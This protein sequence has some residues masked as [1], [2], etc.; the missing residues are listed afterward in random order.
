MSLEE[1]YAKHHVLTDGLQR[2][3]VINTHER[4]YDLDFVTPIELVVLVPRE[5]EEG[6]SSFI[7]SPAVVN[8]KF[9]NRAWVQILKE[10]VI[11]LQSK[12]PKTKEELLAFR[13]DWS[14]API[15]NNF[16]SIDNMVEID[17]GLFF[18]VNYTATHSTWIIGDLL[19]FYDVGLGYIVV[20]RTP[21]AEPQEIREEV[22]RIRRAEFKQFLTSNCGKEEEKA[23][24][25]VKNFDVLNKILS[26]MGTSYND[27]FL[28]DETLSMS[29]YKAKLLKD[30]HKYVYWNESQLKTVRRYL[31]YLTDYYTSVMKVAKNHKE[32]LEFWIPTL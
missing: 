31:D 14:K 26:K 32:E 6:D 25:I 12:S 11:Y 21:A 20:H 16:K 24:K 5:W 29:N 9:E 17:E 8:K 27:F 1:L 30:S 22:G 19:K 3:Y 18:S 7:I 13:T 15:F 10:L 2:R 4:R 28:F 23:D